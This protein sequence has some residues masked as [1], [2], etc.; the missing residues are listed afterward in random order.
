VEDRIPVL[1]D[2]DPGSDIDDA[3]AIA[4]LCKQPRCEL[5]GITTVSGDTPKR[6]AIAEIVCRAYGRED[7]PIVAGARETFAYGVGQ[8]NVPHYDPVAHLPHRSDYA[9][10]QAVDYLRST[11]RSRPG[12]IVLL[13]IGPFTN[14]AL[15]LAIDPE[16][17]SLLRSFVS[18]AGNFF[19][20]YGNEWNCAVDPMATCA[21][22]KRRAEQTWVGLD[23]TTKC[24][25]T[26]DE[27]QARFA[28]P[29]HDVILPMA[30]KWFEGASHITFHD[31]LAA[32]LVFRPDLCTYQGGEVSVPYGQDELKHAGHTVLS[33]G[34][35]PHQVAAT[36]DRDAFFSEY[37]GVVGNG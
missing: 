5:V 32:A 18:M 35:G 13:S 20:G 30:K 3:L 17:P 10:D 6:A 36:V 31:P 2:T 14:V 15:L 4:Y 33:N 21:V 26:P 37:F 1:L 27:V 8:P 34:E 9:P 12:E 23:V 28:T 25:M 11:I 22:A 19:Q 16:I 24:T 7:V 29:P